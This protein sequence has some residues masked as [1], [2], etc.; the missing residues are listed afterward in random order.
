LKRA[1]WIQELPEEERTYH[2]AVAAY[3][4]RAFPIPTMWFS[5]TINEHVLTRE[6]YEAMKSA[7]T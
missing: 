2:N 6:A 4:L 1:Y 5:K 7:K 3:Q